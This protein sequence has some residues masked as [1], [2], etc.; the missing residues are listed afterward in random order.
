VGAAFPGGVETNV[1]LVGSW[2]S[3][4]SEAVGSS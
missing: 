4:W 1:V 2:E 3:S